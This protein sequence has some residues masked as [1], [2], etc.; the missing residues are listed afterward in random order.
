MSRRGGGGSGGTQDG[1]GETSSQKIS[2][3]TGGGNGGAPIGGGSVRYEWARNFI[4]RGFAS[5]RKLRKVD[6]DIT[7]LEV[8]EIDGM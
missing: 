7:D 2:Y 6:A 3:E 4:G 5:R 8:C 1:I